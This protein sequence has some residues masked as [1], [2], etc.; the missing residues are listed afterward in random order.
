MRPL[1]GALAR[2]AGLAV[3]LAAATWIAW[4]GVVPVAAAYGVWAG[5]RGRSGG[6]VA[7][8]GAVLAWGALILLDA[9]GGRMGVMLDVLGATM[10]VGAAALLIATLG[11]AAALAWSGATIASA[12]AGVGRRVAAPTGDRRDERG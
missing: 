1:R 8:L 5:R 11:F 4:W 9:R 6:G 3:A 12:L 2:A 7:A 10:Q